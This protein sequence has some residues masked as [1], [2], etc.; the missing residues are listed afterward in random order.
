MS[1]YELTY[2]STTNT[3]C[4]GI[5]LCIYEMGL[6]KTAINLLSVVYNDEATFHDTIQNS[7]LRDVMK[8]N[9][10]RLCIID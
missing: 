6:S 7:S 4:R 3:V 5:C 9:V 8:R 1:Y 2:Y 10:N